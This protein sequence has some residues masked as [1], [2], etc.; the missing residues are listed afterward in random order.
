M[1]LS[2]KSESSESSSRSRK[3]SD[4]SSSSEASSSRSSSRKSRRR[5]RKRLVP[6][7]KDYRDDGPGRFQCGDPVVKKCRLMKKCVHPMRPSH[8]KG[9]CSQGCNVAMSKMIVG[10]KTILLFFTYWDIFSKNQ[11]LTTKTFMAK[12]LAGNIL[13]SSMGRFHDLVDIQLL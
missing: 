3:S 8:P 6:T 9:R 2:N 1:H 4:Q 7:A 5:C 10:R 12:R 13:A 11:I